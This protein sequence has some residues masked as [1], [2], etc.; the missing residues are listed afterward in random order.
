MSNLAHSTALSFPLI[1]RWIARIL[2][3]M[4]LLVWGFFIVAHLV[5][6][7]GRSSRPLVATDYVSLTTMGL[8]LV[9]LGMAWKWELR[10]AILTLVAVLIGAIANSRSLAFPITLIPLTAGLFLLSWWMGRTQ[11]R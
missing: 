8:S 9:G 10:G 4:I 11:A 3:A 1:I 5:G 7:E 6:D 2:S